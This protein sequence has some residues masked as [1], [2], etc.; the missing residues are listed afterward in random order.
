MVRRFLLMWCLAL[1][2]A[3]PGGVCAQS[4]PAASIRAELIEA[5][6]IADDAPHSAFTDLIFWKDQFICAFRQ[7]RSHVSSD[8]RIAVLSSPDGQSWERIATLTL[9]E[10]DLRDAS[11]SIVPDGR[12]MLLGGAAPRSEDNASA[13]T[14]SFVAFS[15][16]GREW[17]K[18]QVVV[19]PGRWLWRVA[20]RGGK[21]YGVSYAAPDNHPVASL[22]VSDDGV[23]YSELV[24]NLFDQGYP[25]EGVVRFAADGAGYCLLRRDGSL[26]DNSAFLGVSQAPYQEW[27]WHDLREF[28]GGPNLLQLPDGAWIAAGRIIRNGTPTT[29]VALV[30]MAAK[31]LVPI[32]T[33]PSGGDTSYPG[34]VFRNGAL[35]VSYYSGHEGKTSIYIAK[36][37]LLNY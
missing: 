20:W 22:L 11:L 33:L 10:I 28:F 19:E 23:K 16:N 2:V 31:R 25:T 15:T 13:P 1:A 8:G 6:K 5:K 27:Q 29:D 35:W 32:L 30:D 9:D 24:P 4:V 3:S 36:V 26:G 7:G 37:R 14:G 12:L 21:A 34:L 17:T 18:P